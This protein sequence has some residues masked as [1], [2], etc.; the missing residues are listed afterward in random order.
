VFSGFA[1]FYVAENNMYLVHEFRGKVPVSEYNKILHTDTKN[2][3][4]LLKNYIKV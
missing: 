1:I 2:K 3:I 4:N